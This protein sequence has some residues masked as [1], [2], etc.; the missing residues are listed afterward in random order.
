M[1]VYQTL[2]ACLCLTGLASPA[3]ADRQ[4]RYNEAQALDLKIRQKQSLS[5]PK[6]SSP[7]DQRLLQREFQR[8][9]FRQQSLQQRQLRETAPTRA[10]TMFS[11]LTSQRLQREQKAQQLDFKIGEKQQAPRTQPFDFQM[12]SSR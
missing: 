9:Q 12:E 5:L 1:G 11:P 7:S 6:Y 10:P 2:V 8:Q 3:F 4:I